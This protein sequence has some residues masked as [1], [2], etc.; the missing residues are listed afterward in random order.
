[1]IEAFRCSMRGDMPARHAGNILQFEDVAIEDRDAAFN[2]LSASSAGI[3]EFRAIAQSRHGKRGH[4]M[5]KAA[6]HNRALSR[7]AAPPHGGEAP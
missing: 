7:V 2:A 5:R 3:P 1:M 4:A 6:E